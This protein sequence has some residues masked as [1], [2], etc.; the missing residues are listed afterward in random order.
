MLQ[1]V[2]DLSVFNGR[3]EA[4]EFS[5]QKEKEVEETEDEGRRVRG[6]RLQLLNQ[7]NQEYRNYQAPQNETVGEEEEIEEEE[8]D[9][10]SQTYSTKEIIPYK[11][12]SMKGS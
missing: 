8:D 3:T 12:I 10:E 4:F 5:I 7:N 11:V 2:E 1:E 6:R 9:E